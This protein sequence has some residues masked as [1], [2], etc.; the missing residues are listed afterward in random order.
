[1]IW[2]LF[3]SIFKK[4]IKI[5]L[6]NFEG[7]VMNSLRTLSNLLIWEIFSTLASLCFFE[8]VMHS[9]L[10]AACPRHSIASIPK[11]SIMSTTKSHNLEKQWF[12]SSI[13]SF[14]NE[15]TID[16]ESRKIQV[17]SFSFLVILGILSSSYSFF[18]SQII[19]STNDACVGFFSSNKA[20]IISNNFSKSW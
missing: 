6:E 10:G 15:Q 16:H 4:K 17:C 5:I 13:Q 9:W 19:V 8:F 12:A 2:W 14:A 7:K 11:S 20:S 18:F 3:F 1:M